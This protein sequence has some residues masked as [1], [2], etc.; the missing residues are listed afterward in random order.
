MLIHLSPFLNER[1]LVEVCKR[2]LA[3]SDVFLEGLFS[4][5]SILFSAMSLVSKFDCIKKMDGVS[6]KAT[7]VFH[8]ECNIGF[9]FVHEC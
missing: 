9:F 4:L 2:S 1:S 7:T 5:A 3:S 6:S 8:A